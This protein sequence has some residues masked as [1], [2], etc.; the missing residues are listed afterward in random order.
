[1]SQFTLIKE[2]PENFSIGY[3]RT[4]FTGKNSEFSE[5]IAIMP[6][7]YADGLNRALSNTYSVFSESGEK[8]S[9]VGRISMDQSAYGVPENSEF[10]GENIPNSS[11][12]FLLGK[13]SNACDLAKIQNT[14]S[15]EVLINF[16]SSERLRKVWVY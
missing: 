1:Y 5:K 4:Y 7:G 8:F 6:I 2:F 3:G 15:Y 11:K 13:F 10:F 12:I 14:I 16:G 9:C